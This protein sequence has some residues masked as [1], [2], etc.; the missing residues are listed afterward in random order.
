MICLVCHWPGWPM[1]ASLPAASVL[2][3]APWFAELDGFL[4]DVDAGVARE[5]V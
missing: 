4:R 1:Q 5:V 3:P 2:A